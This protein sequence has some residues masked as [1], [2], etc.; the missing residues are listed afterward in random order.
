MYQE[1]L[2]TTIDNREELKKLKKNSQHHAETLA[3]YRYLE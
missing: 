2:Q 3:H 1:F